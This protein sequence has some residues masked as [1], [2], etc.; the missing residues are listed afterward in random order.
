MKL[1]D[2]TVSYCLLLVAWNTSTGIDST[3]VWFSSPGRWPEGRDVAHVVVCPRVQ[4]CDA[5]RPTLRGLE[6]GQQLREGSRAKLDG[7]PK[8]SVGQRRILRKGKCGLVLTVQPPTLA[9][10]RH[11][12][13]LLCTLL[14][15]VR[16][17]ADA[18]GRMEEAV[19]VVWSTLGGCA[20]CAC[21]DT[22]AVVRF[23][24]RVAVAYTQKW[25]AM[26][27]ARHVCCTMILFPP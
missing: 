12:L 6:D 11:R 23:P 14:S 15:R 10:P 4:Q 9:C 13:V 17:S 1:M 3:V 19:V 2:T 25:C 5:L 22:T 20:L 7:V 27:A 16:H 18:V 8:V 26:S 21:H 24:P